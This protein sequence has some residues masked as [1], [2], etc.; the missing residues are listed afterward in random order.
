MTR[1]DKFA[2]FL[3]AVFLVASFLLAA[4]LILSSCARQP[5]APAKENPCY[6]QLYEQV[7]VSSNCT[8]AQLRVDVLLM[9]NNDC[10]SLYGDAGVDVCAKLNGGHDGGRSAHD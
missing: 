10:R 1:R 8:E 7:M 9:A 4:V 3:W 2:A 6:Q 5:Y